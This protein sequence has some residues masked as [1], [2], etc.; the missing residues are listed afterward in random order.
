MKII[1]PEGTCK[2]CHDDVGDL[3]RH[4]TQLRLNGPGQSLVVGHGIIRRGRIHPKL[5]RHKVIV[6]HNAAFF[7]II[8]RLLKNRHLFGAA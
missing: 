7:Q 3:H 5:Q 6:K 8:L 1:L 4:I 2:L